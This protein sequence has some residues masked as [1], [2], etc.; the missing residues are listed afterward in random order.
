MQIRFWGTR[1]SLPAPLT[2]ADIRTKIAA[3]LRAAHGVALDTPAAIDTFIAQLPFSV[4][5]TFGGDSSCVEISDGEGH[6][7]ICDFGSGAR[8][9]GL[10]MLG[11]HGANK[12]QTYHVLMSHLHWDHIMGFPFFPPAYIPGNRILIHGCHTGLEAAFR[13]QHGAPS[14]PVDF[15]RLPAQIE[16]ITLQPGVAADVAGYRV[17]PMRQRHSG[18]SYGYR[19]EKNG[20][21]VV[22]STDSEHRPEQTGELEVFARFFHGADL[23]IFDAMYSLADAASVKEDWGHSSNITGVELCQMARARR[24]CLFHHEPA[25]SD[26]QLEAVLRETRRLEEITRE[27]EPLEIISAHDGLVVN[28]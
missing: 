21:C 8:R 3:A 19:L 18:D 22:Y 12:P 9:Y 15:E 1:G 24:L 17:T 10:E 2:A 7:L 11:R 27:G 14:F 6:N 25:Y 13:R 20:K 4:S 28:F 16:F 26:V 23:V 5:G